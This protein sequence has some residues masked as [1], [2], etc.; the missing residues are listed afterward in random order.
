MEEIWDIHKVHGPSEDTP[1]M[2][3][4]VDGFRGKISR[5]GIMGK[6]NGN[7]ANGERENVMLSLFGRRHPW[8]VMGSQRE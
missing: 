4:G 8:N 1:E 7:R 6:R 3:G 2:S 5:K